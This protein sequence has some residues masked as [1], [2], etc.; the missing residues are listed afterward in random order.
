VDILEDSA[1]PDAS[2]YPHSPAESRA[3]M[4]WNLDFAF[5]YTML[6]MPL[7][8]STMFPFA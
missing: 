2:Q 5:I 7:A 6:G 1:I 8:G 3:N 4:K